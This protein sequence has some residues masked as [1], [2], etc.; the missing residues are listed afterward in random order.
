MTIVIADTSPLNY[1]IL[2]ET[3]DLLPKLYGRIIIP[4]E[5]VDELLHSEAPISVKEWAYALP[6]WVEVRSTPSSN[7]PDLCR[8][9]EGERCAIL[10]A[11]SEADVLLL[12]DDAAGRLEASRRGIPH[13]GTVGVLRAAAIA[14][15]VD[16][17]TALANLVAT[18][19]RI[20]RM[21]LEE[22]LSEDAARRSRT[23][24]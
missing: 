16:L 23:E 2:I 20:S 14:R 18:N 11:Q 8:L 6:S 1:L 12:I 21:L 3:I 7:D 19:F 5:V 9:D 13:A 4:G 17:P 10:L 24:P 22:L 15:H